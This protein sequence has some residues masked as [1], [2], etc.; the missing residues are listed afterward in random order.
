MLYVAFKKVE[1]SINTKLLYFTDLLYRF[2]SQFSNFIGSEKIIKLKM[3]LFPSL[4]SPLKTFNYLLKHYNAKY[5]LKI[6]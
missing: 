5:I 6:T 4:D 1:M 3:F 2:F